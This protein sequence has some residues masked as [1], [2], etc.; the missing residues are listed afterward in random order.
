[1]NLVLY[2]FKVELVGQSVY[3]VRNKLWAQHDL[4]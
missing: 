3:E 4:F 1:M 2:E